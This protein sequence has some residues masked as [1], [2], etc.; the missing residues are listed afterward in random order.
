[1]SDEGGKVIDIRDR[2]PPLVF[3]ESPVGHIAAK[4]FQVLVNDE[5]GPA[6]HLAALVVVSHTLQDRIIKPTV[7]EAEMREICSAALVMAERMRVEVA[8]K[9]GARLEDDD[10]A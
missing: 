9:P 6:E 8:L 10:G 4:L 2:L 1:M 7:S 3:G 5:N